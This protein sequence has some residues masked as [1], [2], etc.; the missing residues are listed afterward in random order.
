M[1]YKQGQT[2]NLPER[3]YNTLTTNRVENVCTHSPDTNKR[4]AGIL[5][6]PSPFTPLTVSQ[7]NQDYSPL[8]YPPLPR[9]QAR[10][11]H[12]KGKRLPFP[13]EMAQPR[14]SLP[15]LLSTKTSIFPKSGDIMQQQRGERKPA[16]STCRR[17]SAAIKAATL[18]WRVPSRQD[19]KSLCNE[20]PAHT[21]R[22]PP[23]P[24][25]AGPRAQPGPRP[26]SYRPRAPGA[27]GEP[28]TG[29]GR[30]WAER[31]PCSCS[32][33][34]EPGGGE[35]EPGPGAGPGG[36]RARAG[37]GLR[38]GW[39]RAAARARRWR[40]AARRVR[41]RRGRARRCVLVGQFRAPRYVA[42]RQPHRDGRPQPQSPRPHPPPVLR[43]WP[44]LT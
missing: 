22:R 39:R 13:L 25:T 8:L 26:A 7:E 17:E 24:R 16:P 14:L 29:P 11:K 20:C 2:H 18:R 12:K 31:L 4:R 3:W 43:Q 37:A 35:K 33:A 41:G 28:G 15:A 23:A 32:R 9:R 21:R 10:R 27:G 5:R 1:Q 44:W 30:R 36:A 34:G 38:G 19:S 42:A 6:M 40:R